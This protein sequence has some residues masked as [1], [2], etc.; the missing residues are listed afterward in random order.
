MR[1]SRWRRAA[2]SF[3]Q[4]RPVAPAPAWIK[5][6]EILRQFFAFCIV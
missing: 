6:I 3:Q 2:R 1:G 4:Q 5:E